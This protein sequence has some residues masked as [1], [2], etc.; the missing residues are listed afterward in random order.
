VHFGVDKDSGLIHS[1]EN[2]SANVHDITRAA[3]LLHGEEEVV[4]GDAGYQGIEK[5]AE[6][7]GKSTA[8]RFA[9]RHGKRRV[10]PDTPDGRLL[11]FVETVKANIRAKVDHPFRAIKQQ[12]GL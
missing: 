9:R 1:V 3:Q 7:A 4:Y 2:T 12:F 8:F 5:R 11:D 10:L 6:M